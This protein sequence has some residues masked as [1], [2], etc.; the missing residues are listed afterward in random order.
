MI[1]IL[2]YVDVDLMHYNLIIVDCYFSI[3]TFLSIVFRLLF[4]VTLK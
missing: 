4:K 3:Y 1:W 2:L